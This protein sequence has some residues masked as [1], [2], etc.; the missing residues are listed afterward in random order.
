MFLFRKIE[1]RIKTKE[2][3]RCTN[4]DNEDTKR[5][6]TSNVSNSDLN[7]GCGSCREKESRHKFLQSST[8]ASQGE[9]KRKKR[10]EAS[11]GKCPGRHFKTPVHK[12]STV[13]QPRLEIKTVILQ[14]PV[15]LTAN[16]FQPSNSNNL[17]SNHAPRWAGG[18]FSRSLHYKSWRGC[19]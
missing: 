3:W 1:D 13:W 14:F 16:Q 15:L 2:I 11:D 18:I 17:R 19:F 9:R 10:G 6:E 4:A 7:H 12:L 5:N 8:S